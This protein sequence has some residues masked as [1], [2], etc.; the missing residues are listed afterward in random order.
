[1]DYLG[2]PIPSAGEV[3]DA[4]VQSTRS[5][6][7][8]KRLAAER[9]RVL[10]S[11][12]DYEKAA[13]IGSLTQLKASDFSSARVRNTEMVDL[14][15]RLRDN[16]IPREYYLQLLRQNKH[17]LCAYCSAREA[18]TLDHYLGKASFGVFA[19]LP[20]NL[21]PACDPC[22]QERASREKKTKST[23]NTL[24]PYYDDVSEIRW[25]RA[26]IIDRNGPVA[27]LYADTAAIPTPYLRARAAEHL[28]ALKLKTYFKAK[29]A[30]AIAG[31]DDILPQIRA[32]DGVSAVVEALRTRATERAVGRENCWERA[33]F[34]A[35]AEDTWYLDTH[36]PSLAKLKSNSADPRRP[37]AL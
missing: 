34:E 4:A 22:N 24:H 19:V 23:A 36:L 14:Y 12:D 3:F 31:L 27:R 30:Q 15:K 10:S 25:L 5:A 16:E 29:S 17:D 8:R 33:L 7:L 32:R 18:R 1:M 2:L 9:A 13:Q 26:R 20:A 21:V 6:P 11:S 28:S 37:F 35:L